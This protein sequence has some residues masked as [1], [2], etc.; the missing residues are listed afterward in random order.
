M[1][2]ILRGLLLCAL[3]MLQLQAQ[4]ENINWYFGSYAGLNFATSPP[5]ILNNSAMYSSEGC[6][7]VSD[8]TGNLLFY[9]NGITIWNKQHQI[10]ANG[11]GLMGHPSSS[12]SGLVLKQPGNPNLYYIFTVDVA[13]GTN[14]FRYTIVD[15]AMAAGNGSV[16]AKNILI[17]APCTEKLTAVKTSNGNDFWLVTHEWNSANFRSYKLTTTGVNTVC[18]ISNAG[19]VHGGTNIQNAVGCM[20][21]SPNGQKL[22]LAISNNPFNVVELFDF[23]TFNGVVSNQCT[24]STSGFV[25]GVEF[26]SNSSK[27]YATQIGLNGMN[28]PALTQWDLTNNNNHLIQTSKF[29][30]YAG[31]NYQNYGMQLAPNGKI[32]I[33]TYN[34]GS[35][36]VINN[37]DLS[38]TACGYSVLSQPLGSGMAL[39]GLPAFISMPY[40]T[41]YFSTNF[42]NQ[43]CSEEVTF[44]PPLNIGTVLTHSS[45]GNYSV[46]AFHWNFGDPNSNYN[47]ANSTTVTH[48]FSNTGNFNVRL[49]ITYSNGIPNDTVKSLITIG[50]KTPTLSKPNNTTLCEKQSLQLNLGAN[51]TLSNTHWIGP[52]GFQS[53]GLSVNINS[54]QT[55]MS[56][57]FKYSTYFAANC[58]IEDSVFVTVLPSPQPVL[59]NATVCLNTPID[60]IGK[61]ANTYKWLGPHGD[62]CNLNIFHLPVN[63]INYQGVYT[64][65]C[66][67]QL[68]CSNSTT[69][70]LTVMDLPYLDVHILPGT[71][72]CLN[73]VLSFNTPKQYNTEW[74]GPANFYSNKSTINVYA[75]NFAMSGNYTLSLRDELGC[76][77]DTIIPILIK[78]LPEIAIEGLSLPACP[79]VQ[80]NYKVLNKNPSTKITWDVQNYQSNGFQFNYNF[81]QPGNYLVKAKVYD[82]K[83]QC[84]NNFTYAVNV[85]PTTK[86]LF[87]YSPSEPIEGIDEIKLHN[88]IKYDDNQSYRWEITNFETLENVKDPVFNIENSGLY[89]VLFTVKNSYGCTDTSSQ[90]IKV[91]TNM[92]VYVPNVFTPNGDNINDIFKPVFHGAN[93]IKLCVFNRWGNKVFESHN[94]D[95]EW[96]GTYAHQTCMEDTYYWTLIYTGENNVSQTKNGMIL[97]MR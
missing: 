10:M 63:N 5:T 80:I 96:D 66:R 70:Q 40:S 53:S 75:N 85:L 44:Y 94:N 7:T 6:S 54:I 21:I 30:F 15:M 71:Q 60:L 51:Q 82:D 24:L 79:P 48:Q 91:K 93:A 32:Y 88:L 12:Q 11:N 95:F 61:G 65:I 42:K 58:K 1:K 31:N 69:M 19:T 27:F 46:T 76:K 26:S 77:S 74:H 81:N 34:S 49:I 37:P 17:Y 64:L 41:R 57:Y 97:L 62:S 83:S 3:S 92:S 16:T 14:G 67:N 89:K 78:S 20:K 59:Q 68:G 2:S 87:N 84:S 18:A 55:T 72:L 4:N 43:Q 56:G 47:T 73:D 50:G 36:T 39:I 28:V 38:G 8:A 90:T 52:N 86:A 45:I 9:T 29:D 13:G 25:Y 22:G 35:L 23:N 33:T